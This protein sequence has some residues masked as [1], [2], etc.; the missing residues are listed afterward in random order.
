M[1]L[2]NIS[3]NLEG[4]LVGEKTNEVLIEKPQIDA[5]VGLLNGERAKLEAWFDERRA[6]FFRWAEENP[7]ELDK[8]LTSCNAFNILLDNEHMDVGN[9]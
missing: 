2:I 8:V 9:D 1:S 4:K 3:L 7:K 5:A 6:S